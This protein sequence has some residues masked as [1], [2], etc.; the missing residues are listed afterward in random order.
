MQPLP[1]CKAI[2]L[3]FLH[4]FFYF[5]NYK[6]T[7]EYCKLKDEAKKADFQDSRVRSKKMNQYCI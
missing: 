6:T 4:S 5:K 7:L 3:V 2:C 1:F